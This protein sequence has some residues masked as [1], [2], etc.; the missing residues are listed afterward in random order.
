VIEGV[1]WVSVMGRE[2]AGSERC[3]ERGWWLDAADLRGALWRRTDRRTRVGDT[4][5]H[6]E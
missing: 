5:S 3:L 4:A 1:V 6:E 2:G